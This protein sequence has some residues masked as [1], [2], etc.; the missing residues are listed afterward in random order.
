MWCLTPWMT[1]AMSP[2][3]GTQPDRHA[4]RL[5]VSA[6]RLPRCDRR[7]RR[8]PGQAALLL[9]CF[10]ASGAEGVPRREEVALLK[11]PVCRHAVSEAWALRW[12]PGAQPMV[13]DDIIEMVDNLCSVS[14]REGRWLRRLD[15]TDV[16]GGKLSIVNMSVFGD[17]RD[18]CLLVRKACQVALKDRQDDLVRMLLERSWS[19]ALQTKLCKK[20]CAKEA[21][22][23]KYARKSEKWVEGFSEGMLETMENRDKLR[24]ETGQIMDVVK[25]EDMDTMSEGDMEV[26]AAQAAFAEQMREAR[27]DR[28]RDW[29][30]KELEL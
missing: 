6:V 11:C 25:R 17:C 20:A 26:Q 22:P 23:L 4:A 19:D 15:V 10:C 13:E 12:R 7:G 5:A 2:L 28:G 8:G 1:S 29:K 24:A 30:G 27:A 9:L 3:L 14:R 18:E 16:A 21:A